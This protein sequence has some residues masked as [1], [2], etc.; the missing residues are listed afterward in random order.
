MF[1]AELRE[2]LELAEGRAVVLL[3]TARGVVLMTRPQL[4]E[5][6]RMDLAGHDLVDALLADRRKEAEREDVG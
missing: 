4:K 1:P 2:R 3:P 6:V 5:A